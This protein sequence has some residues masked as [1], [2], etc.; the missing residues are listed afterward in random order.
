M[1][2]FDFISFYNLFLCFCDGLKKLFFASLEMFLFSSLLLVSSTVGSPPSQHCNP[3]RYAAETERAKAQTMP[4]STTAENAVLTLLPQTEGDASPACL[5]GSKY[6]VYFAAS[7]TGSTKWTISISG[8]GWCYDEVDCLCRSKGPLGTSNNLPPS[9]GKGCYNP[10]PDG[11]LEQDCNFLH[12]PYSDG[13]SFS[14]FVQTPVAVPGTNETVTFRGIKNFDAAVAFAFAHG[15]SAATEFVLTGGSAGGLSTFLHADRVASRL[16]ASAPQCT[17]IRAAPVV[18]YFL[19]HD[20]FAHTTGYPGGPNSPQWAKP[21]TGA[22]YTMWM[23]YIYTMQNLTFGA[24]GA[25]TAACQAKHPTEPHLCFMSPHMNDV[26]ETPFFMFN[27]KYDAW[28]LGNEFQSSWT[29]KAEQ[30]GVLQYGLDFIQQLAPVSSPTVTKNG[31]MITSCICHGCPWPA[32]VLEGKTSFE[33]Y[34]DWYYGKTS[35]RA[36]LHI[37]PRLPNGNGTLNGAAFKSCAT[38]PYA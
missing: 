24:D 14:G 27:S 20:N 2:S 22:N 28:Q 31:G 33:H 29:T 26:I 32:L 19:D 9:V 8:G 34:A 15:L 16:K 18:G 21:G 11:T 30:A 17:K 35:G 1:L 37:D 3:E 4:V 7:T 5:D 38:F 6:G 36:S 23:K 12:L 10:L 13:A 25:L